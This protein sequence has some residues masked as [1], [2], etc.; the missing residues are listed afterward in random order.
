MELYVFWI[1]NKLLI[2]LVYYAHT[3]E[4]KKGVVRQRNS[5]AS[6]NHLLQIGVE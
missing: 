2:M 3:F 5:P 1:S 4:S 6:C